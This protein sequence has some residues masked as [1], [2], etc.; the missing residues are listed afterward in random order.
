MDLIDIPLL[1]WR[2]SGSSCA[3]LLGS[4]Y[5]LVVITSHVS[6]FLANEACTLLL[7]GDSFL[8]GHCIYV[9]CVIVLLL[10]MVLPCLEVV[11]VVRLLR[12]SKSSSFGVRFLAHS[13]ENIHGHSALAV[14]SDRLL[15]P[16][17]NSGWGTV[18]KH[19]FLDEGGVEDGSEFFNQ[20]EVVGGGGCQISG[21][22]NEESK[23]G[24]DFFSS[25][26]ALLQQP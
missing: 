22:G 3:F 7:Q 10:I 26:V 12:F 25:L 20:M 4:L 8:S 2:R 14:D 5:I 16:S 17:I 11:R 1:R 15:N 6:G 24:D 19:Y 18:E 13:S 9:H 21:E 23:L